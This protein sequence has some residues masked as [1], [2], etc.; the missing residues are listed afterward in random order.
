MNPYTKLGQLTAKGAQEKKAF[1]LKAVGGLLDKGLGAGARLIGGGLKRPGILPKALTIGG[2]GLGASALNEGLGYHGFNPVNVD[3]DPL[4]S[5]ELQGVRQRNSPSIGGQMREF[6]KRPIQSIMGNGSMPNSAAE[7]MY[8]NPRIPDSMIK[9]WKKGPDG[10]MQM[11][12]SGTMDAPLAPSYL[13]FL[14]QQEGMQGMPG[15]L[16]RRTGGSGSSPEKVKYI[17]G[18]PSLPGSS[19]F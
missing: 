7:A 5:P 10:K 17:F 3:A 2:V 9:G 4:W 11:Q 12:L 16:G 8:R 19:T 14:R 13:E 18:E 15:M 6:F 1:G